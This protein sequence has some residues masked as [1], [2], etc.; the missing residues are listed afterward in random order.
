MSQAEVPTSILVLRVHRGGD[1]VGAQLATL[2]Q[3]L[4]RGGAFGASGTAYEKATRL[5]NSLAPKPPIGMGLPAP[6]AS[7]LGPSALTRLAE[8]GRVE[9]PQGVPPPPPPQT[10]LP[11]PEPLANMGKEEGPCHEDMDASDDN[12]GL[13]DDASSD[14][15]VTK[16]AGEALLLLAGGP[17]LGA[18]HAECAD[19]FTGPQRSFT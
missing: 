3:N 15:H 17:S 9:L 16:A 6:A 10:L 5:Q 18:S 13:A 1:E 14:R 12:Y 11:Q 19:E 2:T 7:V 8:S 4:I